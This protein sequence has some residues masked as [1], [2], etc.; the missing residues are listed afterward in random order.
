M[1]SV[2]LIDGKNMVYRNAYT[3][4]SLSSGGFPTG[5]I[6]GCLTG[7]LSLAKRLPKT[8][9]VWVW[10]GVGK[11]WR[12]ELAAGVYKANRT[13]EKVK[14]LSFTGS[15]RPDFVEAAQ[16]QIPRLQKFLSMTGFRQFQVVSLEGD[17]LIGILLTHIAKEKLFDEVI[18]YSTDKDFYQFVGSRVRVLRGTEKGGNLKWADPKEIKKDFG[19][20]VTQWTKLRA[21]TGDTSDCIPQIFDGVG[22]KTAAQFIR[23]GVD[24]SKPTFQE[25]S[26]T[27][28]RKYQ[29]GLVVRGKPVDFVKRW[30]DI[31]LNYRLCQIVRDCE[32]TELP[33]EMREG[34]REMLDGLDRNAFHREKLTNESWYRMSEFLMKLEMTELLGA[35]HLLWQIP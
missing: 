23:D 11:T 28:F 9:L 2:V 12:H 24:P 35:R 19:V 33:K 31:Y 25:L 13:R 4:Q 16:R 27:V 20:D 17:D 5:V 6:Y 18:I 30:P 29:R 8:P 10:D 15:E 7:M 3:H 1:S 21:L 32:C 34:L 14:D 22:P 26:K